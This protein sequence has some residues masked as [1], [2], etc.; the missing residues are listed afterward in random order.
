M[1]CVVV[2]IEATFPLACRRS[3]RSP[4]APSSP[5][6][7]ARPVRHDRASPRSGRGFRGHRRAPARSRHAAGDRART[8]ETSV[9]HRTDS[10]AVTRSCHRPAPAARCT[11]AARVRRDYDRQPPAGPR[12]TPQSAGPAPDHGRGAHI[13]H[14]LAMAPTPPPKKSSA[15]CAAD[16]WRGGETWRTTPLTVER[17]AGTRTGGPMFNLRGWLPLWFARIRGGARSTAP[18]SRGYC[19]TVVTRRTTVVGL[20]L[21]LANVL[22]TAS[23]WGGEY[24]MRTCDVP[25]DP[26]RLVGPWDSE[27]ADD[28]PTTLAVVDTCASPDRAVAARDE[29]ACHAKRDF[30]GVRVAGGLSERLPRR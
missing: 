10:A 3:G 1:K 20:A 12:C 30:L 19:R 18:T 14:D 21:V 6:R 11:R 16:G 26:N 23:A 28:A 13:A 27:S 29:L 5:T 15:N 4:K 24:M 2:V 9:G 7:P 17:L 25:G 8:H 22:G